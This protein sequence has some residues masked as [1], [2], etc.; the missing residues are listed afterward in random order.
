MTDAEFQLI[1]A[2]LASRIR[3]AEAHEEPHAGASMPG[4]EI[5]VLHE[6]LRQYQH[7]RRRETRFRIEMQTPLRAPR[8]LRIFRRTLPP[9][10][11]YGPM[12][13]RPEAL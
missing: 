10:T 7:Q 6:L 5:S 1:E 12:R 13:R 8:V 9:L 2:F 3:D 4:V 11:P